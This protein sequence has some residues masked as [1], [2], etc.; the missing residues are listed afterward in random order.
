MQENNKKRVVVT[1]MGLITPLGSTKMKFWDAISHGRSGV[2]KLTRLDTSLSRTKIAST[3]EDFEPNKFIGHKEMKRM[4]RFT[5]LAIAATSLAIEDSGLKIDDEVKGKTGVILGSAVAGIISHE[6]A[7][8]D[9]F[10][11][12]YRHVN[13]LTVPLVMFNAGSSN[14]CMHFG[15]TGISF[16]LSHACS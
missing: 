14:I 8:E 1:G 5:H 7:S 4:D 2:K 15:F 9:L 6:I 10:V 11:R 12:G 16:S 13:P 3:I